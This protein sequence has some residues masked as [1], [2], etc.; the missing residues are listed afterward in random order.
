MAVYHRFKKIVKKKQ[1]KQN[2]GTFCKQLTVTY[3]ENGIRKISMLQKFNKV[4]S[5]SEIKF[6]NSKKYVKSDFIT[7]KTFPFL[8]CIRIATQNLT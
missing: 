2:N 1:N 8:R 4:S 3:Y 7:A 5:A 6:K